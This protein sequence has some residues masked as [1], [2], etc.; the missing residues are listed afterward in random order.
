M[1]AVKKALRQ[2]MLALRASLSDDYRLSSDQ[3][4][5]EH[6]LASELYENAKVVFCFVSM[7]GEVNTQPII[8][9]AIA[10]GKVV[11]VPKVMAKGHMEAFQIKSYN[12]FEVSDYGIREPKAGSLLIEPDQIDLGIIPNIVVSKD[13]YRLGYGGGFYDRYLLRSKMVRLAVC[14]EALIQEVLP[15]EAHDEKVDFIASETGLIE[16]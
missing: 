4:I 2:E 3:A 6:V 10:K 8:E 13:G 12:D 1:K 16:V 11:C 14:R 5:V 9:D 7:P 15:I